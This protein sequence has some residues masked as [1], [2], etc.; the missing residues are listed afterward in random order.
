MRS[1][2]ALLVLLVD[3]LVLLV[4]SRRLLVRDT[5]LL[6]GPSSVASSAQQFT[7]KV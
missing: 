7:S 2:N 6:V 5:C 3:I 1:N 4:V